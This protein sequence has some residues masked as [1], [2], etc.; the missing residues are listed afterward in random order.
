[1]LTRSRKLISAVGVANFI[2]CVAVHTSSYSFLMFS[3]RSRPLTVSI[4]CKTVVWSLPKY[5]PISH[6]EKRVALGIQR[7]RACMR[8][9]AICLAV[10][11]VRLRLFDISTLG[12]IPQTDA[13][14]I[15]I[16]RISGL[17]CMG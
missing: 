9:I 1:M 11:I 12:S 17:S 10:T 6:K 14:F 8:C 2:C 7:E 4:E 13:V 16:S 5:L 15:T 3:Y